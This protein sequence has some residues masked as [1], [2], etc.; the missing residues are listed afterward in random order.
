MI[1]CSQC[2]FENPDQNRFCQNCGQPLRVLQAILTAS[3]SPQLDDGSPS[4]TDTSASAD[5]N[6]AASPI[7]LD[8]PPPQ[9]DL[10]SCVFSERYLDAQQ[11]YQF[12]EPLPSLEAT[13][14]TEI[15]L[16]VIDGQPAEPSTLTALQSQLLAQDETVDVSAQ[17]ALLPP[18]AA[19]YLQLQPKLYPAIPELYDA[20]NGAHCSTLLLEDRTH[21]PLLQDLWQQVE[22]EPL[23]QIHWFYT[24]SELWQILEPWKAQLSLLKLDNLRVDEDQ[25]L[26]LKR[27]YLSAGDTSHSLKDLGLLW[28]ILLQ[29]SSETSVQLPLADLS[30]RLIAG[31]LTSIDHLQTCLADIADEVDIPPTS[32]AGAD[33]LPQ[34]NQPVPLEENVKLPPEAQEDGSDFSSES[35]AAFDTIPGDQSDFPGIDFRGLNDDQGL[36]EEDDTDSDLLFDDEDNAF[37]DSSDLPTMVLPMKL[38]ALEEVGCTHIGKQRDHNEDSFFAETELKKLDAPNGQTLRARGL[39]ILCDGMGGHAGGEVASALAVSTLKDYFDQHWQD[40][41]PSEVMIT[42]AIYQT[43]HAIY[44]INQDESRSGSARMGTTLV[45]VLLQDTKAVV[46]HVG[47]SRLYRFTRRLGLQ[48]MT[49]D[50]EV[51]QREIQ[52]GVEPAIAYARPDAFQL[53]Q[54]LGPRDRTDIKPSIT[55]IDIAEDTLLILCSD[56]LSDNDLLESY[57]HTHVEPLLR[58]RHDLEEGVSQLIDLGNEHNGHDN[59]TAI[60]IRIKVRPNLEKLHR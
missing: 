30:Q 38:V 3:D 11:R 56:G 8:S 4:A 40:D 12:K 19:P 28:Q 49:V 13:Q 31:D 59:L 21:F 34:E 32:A 20:W 14:H 7:A 35:N 9:L 37:N 41:L 33:S 55:A 60:A 48:Q 54:A 46:A 52:R 44:S 57:C 47:D 50:H 24:M 25:I 43:N 51:G 58:S 6:L 36:D 23:Q 53:T 16:T 45:M 26:C 15:E 10:Q 27:L 29:Q 17:L 5:L 2:Q 22:I 18:E 1:V 42:D 39:Y